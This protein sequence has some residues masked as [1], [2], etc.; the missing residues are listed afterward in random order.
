MGLVSDFRELYRSIR[1]TAQRTAVSH[2]RDTDSDFICNYV[3]GSNIVQFHES[4]PSWV[5]DHEDSETYDERG[6]IPNVI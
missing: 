4:Q 5:C 3:S 1:S 2:S 6:N